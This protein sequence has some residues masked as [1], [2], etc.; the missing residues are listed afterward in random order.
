MAGRVDSVGL[1]RYTSRFW[2]ELEPLLWTGTEAWG[3]RRHRQFAD[4][5]G[6]LNLNWSDT[7][8]D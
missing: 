2:I 5:R 4:D 6:P 1:G 3:L 8:D 7:S